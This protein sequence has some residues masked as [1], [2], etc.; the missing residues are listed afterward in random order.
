MYRI[1]TIIT[2]IG[3]VIISFWWFP[4]SQSL[5]DMPSKKAVDNLKVGL[6]LPFSSGGGEYAQEILEGIQHALSPVLWQNS[7]A[8]TAVAGFGRQKEYYNKVELIIRDHQGDHQR[9]KQLAEQLYTEDRVSILIGGLSS[10]ESQAYSDIA[11]KHQRLFI[12]L[13]PRWIEGF[14][15]QPYSISFTASYGWQA[16]V[17][18]DYLINEKHLNMMEPDSRRYLQRE[19]EKFLAGE[20]YDRAE[21]YVPPQV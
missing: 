10:L 7:P 13:L 6:L 9:A 3:A 16:K 11:Q 12:S 20:D 15:T 4:A 18:A 2:F 19:M 14:A 1:I 17:I 8:L 21:G 5:D